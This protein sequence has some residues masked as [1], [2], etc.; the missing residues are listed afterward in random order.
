MKARFG[1]AAFP[2]PALTA[3]AALL[4]AVALVLIAASIFE[5]LQMLRGLG[6]SINQENW[7]VMLGVAA[8]A[9]VPSA[10]LAFWSFKEIKVQLETPIERMR[11][12]RGRGPSAR[13]SEQPEALSR[14]PRRVAA[15]ASIRPGAS[16][17]MA[18]AFC[19]ALATAVVTLAVAGVDERGIGAALVLTGRL[20]FLI[21]WPAYVGGAPATLFGPRFAGLARRGRDFGLAYAS[22]QLVHFS[23]VASLVAGSQRPLPEAVMPFFAIGVVWT[24]LLAAFSVE[25]IGNAVGQN[26]VRILRNIGL[27]YLALIFFVDLV[28]LPLGERSGYPPEYLPFSALI[29]VGPLLRAAASFRRSDPAARVRAL[30]KGGS[31]VLKAGR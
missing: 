7:R 6:R 16:L 22:A 26:H 25:R 10:S 9:A 15:D 21:F 30:L 23:L 11:Q 28:L 2:R 13:A 3:A 17:W 24:Y 4:R 27:E 14:S 5:M 31:G 8:A 18:A 29:I 19:A 20:S 1:E 12:G